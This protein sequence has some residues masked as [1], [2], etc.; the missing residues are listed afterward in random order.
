MLRGL[1]DFDHQSSVEM[2]RKVRAQHRRCWRNAALS[3]SHLGR[4]AS[5]VEG[6]IVTDH[7]T[8][9][10]IEHGWCEID[11]KVIDPTYA[12]HVSPHAPPVGYFPGRRYTIREAEAALL[13]RSLP[14]IWSQETEAYWRSFDLAWR[15]TLQH[16]GGSGATRTTVV[17]CRR[18]EFDVFIGRPS[19]WANPFHIGPD[20]TRDQ[21]NHKYLVWLIRQP[22]MLR[23]VLRIREKRL[24]CRCTPLACH[25]DVLAALA[26]VDF[27]MN[28]SSLLERWLLRR[29]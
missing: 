10:V 25:G 12:P 5:Y 23:S 15:Y 4:S 13:R 1:E 17:H 18:E 22:G 8:P 19:G 3:V 7:Q 28:G 2:A 26:N 6:W 16:E 29:S 24:G 9:F 21:V 14:I 20:G 11:G 27:D